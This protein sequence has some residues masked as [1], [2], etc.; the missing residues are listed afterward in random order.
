MI[1]IEQGK[2]IIA[3]IIAIIINDLRQPNDTI[4]LLNMGLNSAPPIPV[5]LEHIP[6]TSPCLVLNQFPK[7]IV[8]GIREKQHELIPKTIEA[9]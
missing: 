7:I 4:I 1:N 6:I 3:I 2:A 9:T 8:T 5:K